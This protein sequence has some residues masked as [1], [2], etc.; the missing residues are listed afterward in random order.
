M[1]E[2]TKDERRLAVRLEPDLHKQAHELAAM[3]GITLSD[4]IRD[5]LSWWIKNNINLDD[6]K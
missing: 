3:Q 5:L 4:A 6:L 2:Q 1:P